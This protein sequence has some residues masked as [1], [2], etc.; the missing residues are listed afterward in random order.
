M[1][2]E[3]IVI[4]KRG[5]ARIVFQRSE[6]GNALTDFMIEKTIKICDALQWEDVNDVQLCVLEG[7]GDFF[8]CGLDFDEFLN[9]K[10][11]NK[12]VIFEKSV[13][14]AKLLR[15]LASLPFP[16]LCKVKGGALGLG[17][18]LV[19]VSDYV[20]AEEDSIFGTPE[21]KIG[22]PPIFTTL[23]LQRR[24]GALSASLF[25]LSGE[26]IHAK[27]AVKLNIVNRCFLKESF[28]S[29]SE[30]VINNFL[31][32]APSALRKMKNLFL[33]VYPVP[34]NEIEEF[35]AV[36]LVEA[37][38]SEEFREGIKSFKEKRIPDWVKRK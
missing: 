35:A 30:K 2:E 10:D 12:E 36:Q 34:Q 18:G 26:I 22:L 19:A 4:I 9:D 27:E 21:I 20:I 3:V 37:L 14:Q 25:S 8:C 31:E 6:K 17:L 23:Y 16:L 11:S 7:E 24:Y 38:T 32:A 5:I 15:Q 29:E 13:K 1:A 33:K 28:E